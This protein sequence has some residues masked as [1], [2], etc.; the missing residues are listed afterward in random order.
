MAAG[1]LKE[2]W[3][4]LREVTEDWIGGKG[5]FKWAAVAFCAYLL[6]VF[7]LGIYWSREPQEIAVEQP[8]SGPVVVGTATTNMLI[9]VSETLLDKPGG[10]LTNDITPPGLFLDN[11]P[12]WEYGVLIQVRDL[13]RAL[14]ESFSRSQSQSTEDAA[15][16]KAGRCPRLSLNTATG[17]NTSRNT[18]IVWPTWMIRRR[19]FTPVPT[20][21]VTG[22][23]VWSPAWAACPS[24]SVPVLGSAV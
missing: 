1:W 9:A 17:S 6:L 20:I 3:Q 11:M 13:T 15:L 12:A 14:R 24:V 5:S 16:A 2:R 8:G 19:S 22:W 4:I 10:F 18:A 21:C 7:I 23:P